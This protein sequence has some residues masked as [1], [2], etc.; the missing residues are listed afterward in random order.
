MADRVIAARA[1]DHGATVEVSTTRALPAGVLTP[2]LLSENV[3]DGNVLRQVISD[4][5]ATVGGRSR[6]V[7]VLLP[8]AAARVVLLEFDAL[9]DK[10]HEAEPVV[11]FRL[12]K[13][14]PFDVEKAVLS[15]QAFPFDS[16]VRVV[17]AVA[18]SSVLQ[19]Y[20]SAFREA[21]YNPG[22]VLPATLAALG[23]VE[24]QAPTLV[25]KL[26]ATTT[27]VA[28]LNR[29]QLLLYRTIENAGGTAIDP[30]SLAEEVYPSVVFFEDTYGTRVERILLAD[31]SGTEELAAALEAQTGI[32]PQEL[33]R[34]AQVGTV[35]GG[36]RSLLAG[37]VGAFTA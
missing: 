19:E 36:P 23:P 7:C 18:L 13:S 31:V 22:V 9:P 16:G 1:G 37:V 32:R 8:D 12:K 11:R 27:C 30:D 20:E 34:P 35:A 17:A 5:L 24:A 14:L 6:E 4:A 21:G 25:V 26:D 10:I 28:M 3:Q 15:F 29:E 33:V 2:S